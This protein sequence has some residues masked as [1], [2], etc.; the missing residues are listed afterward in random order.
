MADVAQIIAQ[1]SAAFQ[2]NLDDTYG[3]LYIGLL[4]SVLCV[5]NLPS[6]KRSLIVLGS[7][8]GI[9]NLQVYMYFQHYEEDKLWV[10]LSVRA[11][12][13]AVAFCS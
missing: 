2:T 6:F 7:F 8:L 12:S 4:C 13:L 3:A 1:C 11:V 10:K 9:S 5:S